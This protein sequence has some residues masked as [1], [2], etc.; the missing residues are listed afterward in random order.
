MVNF[1]IFLDSYGPVV[2]AD[3]L[4]VFH[5]QGRTPLLERMHQIPLP[6]A[7]DIRPAV[8]TQAR[9][10]GAPDRTGNSRDPR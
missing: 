4:V 10:T 3:E 7:G 9:T 1:K 2:I 6:K 5:P 8:P